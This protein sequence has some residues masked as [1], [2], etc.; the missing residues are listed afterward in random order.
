LSGGIGAGKSAVSARLARRGAVV[1]DADRLAREVVAPGTPGFEAVVA[2]FGA[3]LLLPDGSLDRPALGRRVFADDGARRRLEAIV[4][5]LVGRRTGELIA[6]A[7]ADAVV[8]HD[9]PLL[10]EKGM[11]PAYHLVVVVGAPV[12][13]R[14]ARLVDLRGMP[15]ADARARIDA[16]ADDVARRAAADVWLDNAGDLA[17]LDAQVDALWDQR[18]LPY[19]ANVRDGR[20]APRPDDAPVPYDPAWPV[21]AARVAARLGLVAGERAVRIDH[22]GPTAVPGRAAPDVLDLDLTVRAPEDVR[23][24]GPVLREVGFPPADSAGEDGR[25]ASADPGRP[26]TLRLRVPAAS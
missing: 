22:V 1:V 12:E 18:L 25:Y 9:V 2:E 13:T 4:H 26:A 21:Q 8:V 24:L 15:A 23:G 17:T 10:V 3:D 5:P 19:E 6:A 16:Q 7:P 20:P 14:L 11:G